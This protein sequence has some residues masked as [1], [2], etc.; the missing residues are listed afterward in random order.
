VAS[1]RFLLFAI[2]LGGD[3]GDIQPVFMDF[4]TA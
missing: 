3:V 2:L 4:V 1:H